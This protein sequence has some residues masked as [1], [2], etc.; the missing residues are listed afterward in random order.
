[1]TRRALFGVLAAPLLPA[2]GGDCPHCGERRGG[3]EGTIYCAECLDLKRLERIRYQP[4]V[5]DTLVGPT[6]NRI[7]VYAIDPTTLDG[8]PTYWV[9]FTLTVPGKGTQEKWVRLEHWSDNPAW[10]VARLA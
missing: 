6:G 9:W 7:E 10:D 8:V 3:V 1:M 5:G 2:T 4:A